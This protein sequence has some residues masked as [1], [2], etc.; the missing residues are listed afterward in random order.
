M[1]GSAGLPG[2]SLGCVRRK[3]GPVAVGMEP[4]R[5]LLYS[6]ALSAWPKAFFAVCGQRREEEMQ[7]A[8]S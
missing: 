1:G 5:T 8:A 7:Y 4:R 3:D 2:R 6:S